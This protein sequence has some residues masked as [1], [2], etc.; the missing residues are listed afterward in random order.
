MY[1]G[2]DPKKEKK[3]W[4]NGENRSSVKMD[5]LGQGV[6]V[7]KKVEK[8]HDAD[9]V[10]EKKQ[11]GAEKGG[12]KAA[13][14]RRESGEGGAEQNNAFKPVA[15]L[16]DEHH[17]AILAVQHR[18]LAENLQA[19]ADD[20][21]YACAYLGVKIVRDDP[22]EAVRSEGQQTETQGRE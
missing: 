2:G 7:T 15:F 18:A 21:E 5:S 19:G 12:A 9:D 3:A 20:V 17:G 6:V 13:Q 14:G 1:A 11:D 10:A 22:A 4:K 16:R 8:H